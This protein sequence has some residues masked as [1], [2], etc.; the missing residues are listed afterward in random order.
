MKLI[1]HEATGVVTAEFGGVR[2]TLDHHCYAKQLD[3]AAGKGNHDVA[4]DLC[5]IIRQA[6]TD[7]TVIAVKDDHRHHM[8]FGIQSWINQHRHYE[9]GGDA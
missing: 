2:I 7:G 1:T 8:A 6:A 5:S 4:S 3:D 9:V